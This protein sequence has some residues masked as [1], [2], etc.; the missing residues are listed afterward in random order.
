MAQFDV[1]RNGNPASAAEF[2]LLLDVQS[3]LHDGLRTRLV[4]P[5]SPAEP[6]AG[7]IISGLMPV[8]TIDGAEFAMLTP[9]AA[10]IPTRLLGEHVANLSASR[11]EIIAAL[12][13]LLTGL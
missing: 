3:G 7:R 8:L 5:L 12:D 2:P 10:G 9:Q 4:V 11:Q 13:L 1:H 6:M